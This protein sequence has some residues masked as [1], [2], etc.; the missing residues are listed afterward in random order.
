VRAPDYFEAIRA[1]RAW[2]VVL[3]QRKIRLASGVFQTLWEP[4]Q[5]LSA[6]CRRRHWPFPHL[7]R[8][9]PVQHAAP[10]MSC[11]CGVYGGRDP[12]AAIKY[13]TPRYA[14]SYDG[15]LPWP[16]IGQVI[17][18]VSLW[19]TVIECGHG[20]RAAAAYPHDLLVVPVGRDGRA[21]VRH[22]AENVAR[23]LSVYGVPVD[24][25]PCTGYNEVESLLPAPAAA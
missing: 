23:E 6:A 5:E 14:T 13:L 17:G 24:V 1:W 21:E 7:G 22:L 15:V 11:E 20:W 4:R 3:D 12:R 19:G 16:V 2:I 25:L 10:D 8:R 9:E 18:R